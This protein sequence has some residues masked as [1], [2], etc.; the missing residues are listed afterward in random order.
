M[1]SHLV[2]CCIGCGLSFDRAGP[3]PSVDKGLDRRGCPFQG[4]PR[5]LPAQSI[6]PAGHHM[7][8]MLRIGRMNATTIVI[9][10]ARA[11]HRLGGAGPRSLRSAS[12]AGLM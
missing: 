9:S 4:A 3:V 8:G 1:I 6:K 2:C 7:K 5:C 10:G 11:L 12:S